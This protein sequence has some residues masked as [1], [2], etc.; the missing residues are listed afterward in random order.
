MIEGRRVRVPPALL[1][2]FAGVLA[3]YVEATAT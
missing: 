1:D 2:A 3:P